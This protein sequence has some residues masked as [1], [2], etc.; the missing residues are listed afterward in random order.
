MPIEEAC[1]DSIY[2]SV[3]EAHNPTSTTG[4]RSVEEITWLALMT[5]KQMHDLVRRN[6]ENE[7]L[8]N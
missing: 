3:I 1:G 5:V 8:E 6:L 4:Q 2:Q 7:E